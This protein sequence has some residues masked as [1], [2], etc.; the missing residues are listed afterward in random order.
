MSIPAKF[1]EKY[2]R[3]AAVKYAQKYALSYNTEYPSY[4]PSTPTTGKGDCMNFVSQC[5]HAGGMPMKWQGFQWFGAKNRCNAAWIGAD[6]FLAF[7]RK[8]FGSPRLLIECFETPEGLK[9]GDFVFTV[10]DGKAGLITRNPSHIV[11]LSEDYDGGED[12]IV[13]GH[14]EDQLNKTK[15]RKDRKCTYIHIKDEGIAYDYTEEDYSDPE[16]VVTAQADFGENTLKKS[17]TVST[18][19]KNLQKRL[20][21]L[22]YSCGTVDGKYGTNTEKAVRAFQTACAARFG[23][24]IDGLAGPATKEALIYP[25]A[26]LP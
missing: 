26:M 12:L 11:I 24:T 9:K 14:T 7:I 6:S 15:A 19:V 13:C 20:N 5:I 4:K 23:L 17:S 18:P 2:D 22:G 25:S 3:D 21:Y 1:V 8:T 16:D 10:P